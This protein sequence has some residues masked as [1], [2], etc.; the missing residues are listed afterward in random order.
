MRDAKGDGR[1]NHAHPNIDLPPEY[2]DQTATVKNFFGDG[3]RQDD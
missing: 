3:D 2:I 1:N